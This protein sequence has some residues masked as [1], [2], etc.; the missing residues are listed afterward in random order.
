V[1]TLEPTA[2][3]HLAGRINGA[4][5]KHRLDYVETDCTSVAAILDGNGP[6][7]WIEIERR[8]RVKAELGA[9]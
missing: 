2:D 4:H 7:V 9:P 5:L 8:R 3:H 6:R 1:P